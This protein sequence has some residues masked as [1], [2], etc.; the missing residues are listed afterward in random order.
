[1]VIST[2]FGHARQ[3]LLQ[4]MNMSATRAFQVLINVA[5]LERRLDFRAILVSSIQ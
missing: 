1:M 4:G 2:Y 5:P 3:L